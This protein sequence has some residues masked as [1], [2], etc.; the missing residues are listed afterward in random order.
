MNSLELFKKETLASLKEKLG[1]KNIHEVPTLDK[2]VVSIWIGSLAT[3][4]SVKDFDEFEKNLKKI[5]GQKPTL[6]K[7]RKSISNFKLREGMP[8]MLKV[9]LR[10]DRAYN[11]IEKFVKVVLPRLRDFSGI[12]NKSFD[13]N[14][15][16]NIWL[17]NYNIFPEL[18]LD[19]VNVN[20]WL[21][22]TIVTKGSRDSVKSKALLEA[23]WLIFK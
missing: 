7:S 19:D 12:S 13:A 17:V 4:K 14:W 20:M 1:V 5:T 3:R 16:Y 15:N 21:Q 23:L 6:I 2:V 22:M 11:F 9:T 10:R 8:V 18:N